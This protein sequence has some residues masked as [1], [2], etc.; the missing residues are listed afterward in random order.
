[1]MDHPPGPDEVEACR[2][3]SQALG[4]HLQNSS[5][6]ALQLEPLRRRL[7]RSAGEVDRDHVGPRSRERLRV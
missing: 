7:D 6:Q 5:V 3:E 1:M 4:V 2:V